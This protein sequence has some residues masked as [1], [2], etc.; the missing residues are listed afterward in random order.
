MKDAQAERQG[1]NRAAARP[2]PP[3][4]SAAAAGESWRRP[5]FLSAS[6][7]CVWR[8][9]DFRHKSAIRHTHVQTLAPAS[10]R[11]RAICASMERS[12]IS[13]RKMVPPSAASKRP[14]RLCSAPVKAPFSSSTRSPES[15]RYGVGKTYAMAVAALWWLARYDDGIVLTTSSTFRQVKSSSSHKTKAVLREAWFGWRSKRATKAAISRCSPEIPATARLGGGAGWIRT[16]GA[17]RAPLYTGVGIGES[18]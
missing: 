18:K 3:S 15:E 2:P 6:S 1:L 10:T 9:T 12:P 4:R 8:I 14:M 16:P 13:S 11:S 5:A 17:A 7:S